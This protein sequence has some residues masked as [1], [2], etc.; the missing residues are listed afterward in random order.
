MK[1]SF[2]STLTAQSAMRLTIQRNQVEIQNLRR[3]W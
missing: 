2:I 1:T 3:K